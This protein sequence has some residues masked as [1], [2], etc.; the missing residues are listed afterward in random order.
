MTRPFFAK[1]LTF[2][3]AAAGLWLGMRYFLPIFLPFL[4]AAFLALTAEGAV[5]WMHRRLHFPRPLASG[6]GVG[7]VF[8]LF[9]TLT[10]LLLAGLM[11]QIPRLSAI[12]PRLE[13]AILSGREL[14]QQWLLDLA[15]RLPGSIGQVVSSW[16]GSLFSGSSRL[17]EP[18][19]EKLPGLVTGTV[20]KMSQG[21][22]GILTGVIASFM[23]S[24]RLPVLRQK[25]RNALPG[26]LRDRC[27]A[28][29]QGLRR[30][31][32]GWLLAQ[33]KLAGMTLAV[34]IVG[35]LILRIDNAP[36]WAFLITLVD[37]FPILGVGTVLVPWSFLCLL[38]GNYP[39][40][41]GLLAVYAVAWLLRSVLEPRLV[42]KGLGLDPLVTLGAIYAGF[43]LWGI[44]GMLLAPFGVMAASQL[45]RSFRASAPGS[46][47]KP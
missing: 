41:I 32:G 5:S 46:G 8:V 43:Q 10:V 25:L 15:A 11:W 45:W 1:I 29:L 28:A 33:L 22:F 6:L 36:L 35:F 3:A 4:F 21:L 27:T 47:E 2:A 20:G 26:T 44:P 39:L 12:V 17:M 9:L 18:F 30:A 31:L 34:L 24:V 38:Q 19:L 7:S 16:A 40:G 23:L 42:G 14:L 13:A 37:A